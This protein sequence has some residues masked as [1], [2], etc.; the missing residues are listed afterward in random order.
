MMANKEAR[1]KLLSML[2]K[3]AFDPVIKAHP[4]DYSGSDQQK[5][6]NVQRKTHSTKQRYHDSY[7]TAQAVY[8]NFK[9]DLSSNSA[10]HVHQEIRSLGLPTLQDIKGDF[11]A[12][13]KE[14]GVKS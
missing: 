5:L 7:K 6:E 3:K 12:L 4:K 11:E 8:D 14:L 13:A 10:Q 9:S 1:E 2:D